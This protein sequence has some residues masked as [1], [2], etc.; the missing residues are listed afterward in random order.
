M[1][2]GGDRGS[3]LWDEKSGFLVG[4]CCGFGDFN[5]FY[6]YLLLSKR[7]NDSFVFM[8]FWLCKIDRTLFMELAVLGVRG[9]AMPFSWYL[10]I[11]N[12]DYVMM[13]FMESFWYDYDLIYA[14]ISDDKG[15][16]M[17]ASVHIE[18]CGRTRKKW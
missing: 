9:E 7:R 18:R 4:L 16:R 1:W 11:V 12:I 6:R 2:T 13:E 17:I 3:I 8:S 14:V 15:V 10:L 5:C